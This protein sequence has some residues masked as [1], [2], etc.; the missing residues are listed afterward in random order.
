MNFESSLHKLIGFLEKEPKSYAVI[1]GFA[2]G[3]YGVAR[4]TMDLDFLINKCRADSLKDFMHKQ[5][6]Q[7]I[8]ESENV[9]QFR[10]PLGAVGS[11]DFLY[12]F[13]APSLEM[14]VRSKRHKIFQ[15]QIVIKALIPED[16]IGLKIQ[17]M[18]NNP[19]RKLYD[20]DDI[21]RLIEGN[22]RSIEWKII[23]KHFTLF[24]QQELFKKLKDSYGGK[25][26]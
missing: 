19:K 20:A 16:L 9:I 13:R 1:G 18:V 5:K 10:S 11:V 8:H 15:G 26:K 6:A 3:L 12:A 7:I 4:A 17:A 2:L 25:E 22:E 23:E 24:G 14:L 21:R